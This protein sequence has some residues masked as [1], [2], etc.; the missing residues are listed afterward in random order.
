MWNSNPD[1]FSV[2]CIYYAALLNEPTI[3][4]LFRFDV[5][6]NNPVGRYWGRVVSDYTFTSLDYGANDEVIAVSDKNDVFS[7]MGLNEKTAGKN[8]KRISKGFKSV[9]TSPYGYWLLNKDNRAYFS[10]Y[11][12]SKTVYPELK[13]ARI[14]GTFKKISAGFGGNVWALDLDG[15]VFRR[16]KVNTLTPSGSAWIQIG[17]LKLFDLAAGYDG[18]YGITPAGRIIRY[19]GLCDIY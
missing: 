4:F 9:S 16:R 1:R 8:W 19:T 10:S 14:D 7:R 17:N 13:L 18:V 2:L 11:I 6:A 5:S 15:N 3:I 12:S